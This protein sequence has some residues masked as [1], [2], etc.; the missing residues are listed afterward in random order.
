LVIGYWLLVI[1]YWWGLGFFIESA[2]TQLK[3]SVK[4]QEH[5]TIGVSLLPKV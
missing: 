1:G 4:A 2:K 5:L 3:E